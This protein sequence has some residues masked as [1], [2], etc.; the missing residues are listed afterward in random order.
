LAPVLLGRSRDPK[1]ETIWVTCLVSAAT[2]VITAVASVLPLP[3]FLWPGR[4]IS[5]PVDLLSAVVLFAA[6]LAFIREYRRGG[7]RLVWWILLAI[8]VHTAGQLLM[9]FSRSL[10]DPFFD[11]A[12]V[13]KL[14]GYVIPLLGFVLYQTT[15]ITDRCEAERE[16]RKH[17]DDLDKLVNQRTAQLTQA[18]ERLRLA[19]SAAEMG[20]WRWDAAADRDTRDASFNRILGLEAVESTQPVGDFLGRVHPEDRAAVEQAIRLAGKGERQYATEFRVVRPDGTVRWLR[21]QG[22]VFYDEDGA[23]SH[24][25][26]AVVDI[27]GRGYTVLELPFDNND[28]FG[29][30]TDLVRHFLESMAAEAR[31]NLHARIL[32]GT[33]DH[34]KVEALFKA[35]GRALDM[36][37]R[38]DE[39]ISGELPSTK[40]LLE[41]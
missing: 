39:R 22:K 24:M 16:L 29:F 13:Y 7:D 25:T 40:E 23:L 2:V 17:R 20:T 14:A 15:V 35:L 28:M 5:R 30:P 9:S 41:H 21:D 8:G 32:Y 38:T 36:A 19:L 37:T 33:N 12:H 6:L 26:G 3:R 1:R 34:H 31:L 10:Y 4:L 27:S 18:N 11:A